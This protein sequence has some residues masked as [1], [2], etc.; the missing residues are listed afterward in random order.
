[1]CLDLPSVWVMDSVKSL[2]KILL[3]ALVSVFGTDIEMACGGQDIIDPTGRGSGSSKFRVRREREALW[4]C[5]WSVHPDPSQ[6]TRRTPE[7]IKGNSSNSLPDYSRLWT[8]RHWTVVPWRANSRV[9]QARGWG[10][11]NRFLYPALDNCN[12]HFFSHV[13][14]LPESIMYLTWGE[15][16]KINLSSYPIIQLAQPE[17]EA[18]A[19]INI[20]DHIKWKNVIV[21]NN[22]C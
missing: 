8:R 12:T 20:K 14:I 19:R 21:R 1:M 3:K 9:G 7:K 5:C 10:H 17:K 2:L 22:G 11:D 18:V 16:V 13:C 4:R 6:D 15:T